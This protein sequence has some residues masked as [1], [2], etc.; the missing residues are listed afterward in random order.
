MI[1]FDN[2]KK[3]TANLVKLRTSRDLSIS[4][5]CS[6]TGLSQEEYLD[7]ENGDDDITL[8]NLILLAKFYNVSVDSI[9]LEA[10]HYNIN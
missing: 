2:Y 4:T 6:I 7:V 3:I 5:I 10:I 8:D 1:L 9:I